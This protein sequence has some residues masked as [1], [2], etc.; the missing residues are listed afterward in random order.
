MQT[1]LGM[2]A[3]SRSAAEG[4][5]GAAERRPA[6]SPTI[7]PRFGPIRAA[8]AVDM[9]ESTECVYLSEGMEDGDA[10][11]S[12][13]PHPFLKAS[14]AVIA[15]ASIGMVPSGNSLPGPARAG[16]DRAADSAGDQ[17]PKAPRVPGLHQ[18]HVFPIHQVT[19]SYL[20]LRS[21]QEAS[22]LI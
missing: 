3:R 8:S 4:R 21:L 16:D 6:T 9:T 1:K 13:L 7:R 2:L 19:A 15:A 22:S 11:P 5:R 12:N 18:L 20:F 10:M 17:R 14:E